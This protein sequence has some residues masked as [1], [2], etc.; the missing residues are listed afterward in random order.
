MG[1][2]DYYYR[3]P[4]E[5]QEVII[6]A[7]RKDTFSIRV[8]EEGN[9]TAMVNLPVEEIDRMIAGLQLAKRKL[10]GR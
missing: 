4:D 6:Q 8:T 5:E 7:V 2:H 10:Q 1:M 3:G 9:E